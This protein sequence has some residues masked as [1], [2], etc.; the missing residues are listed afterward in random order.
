MDRKLAK[1]QKTKVIINGTASDWDSVTNGVPQGSVLGPFLF[2][3]YMNDT[4]VG[5]NNFISKFA[6]DAK[7][8]NWMITDH[9][10]MSLQ[11]DLRRIKEWCHR[12]ETAF[13]VK[14]FHILQKGT[15]NQKFE[16]EMND[17]KL[18]TA[19]CVKDL[20]VPI[21]SRLKFS[22]QCKDAAGKASRM[23][24]FINR[25]FSFKIKT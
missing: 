15:R 21:A 12:R 9:D 22:Q 5:L 2:K 23:P 6:D 25:N 18:K 11:E 20:G 19:Q 8:G 10:R 3:I 7:I 1:E 14:E 13:N 4:D 17:T 24:G 16:Y